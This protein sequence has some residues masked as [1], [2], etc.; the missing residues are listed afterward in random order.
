MPPDSATIIYK[1]AGEEILRQRW[2][3]AA[4]LVECES[5]HY[6]ALEQRHGSIINDEALQAVDFDLAYLA[7]A[8]ALQSPVLFADYLRWAN[9]LRSRQGVASD[10]AFH[11]KCMAEFLSRMLPPEFGEPA[12]RIVEQG[13]LRLADFP[14]YI[15]SFIQPGGLHS[16]LARE[17]LRLLLAG[18]RNAASALI[19]EAVRCGVTVQDL[20]LHVFQQ[21]QYEIGR[22]WQINEIGVAKAKEL[23]GS[24]VSFANP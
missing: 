16:L 21:T 18:K 7:S 12:V 24:K 3:A 15:P 23:T 1:R 14:A 6:L 20:Y 9:T 19:Q 8:V 11:L 4:A 13:Q 5:A 10:L 17:Y 2:V 22:L